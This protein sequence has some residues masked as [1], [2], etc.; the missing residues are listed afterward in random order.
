[1]SV[2]KYAT[3]PIYWQTM[4]A[5]GRFVEDNPLNYRCN[6][7]KFEP[8]NRCAPGFL[9]FLFLLRWHCSSFRRRGRYTSG[10]KDP[11]VY[12]IR[13]YNVTETNE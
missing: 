1:M 9:S 4:N 11:F 13:T 7:L 2:C 10:G 6:S 8:L 3:N 5:N 12:P